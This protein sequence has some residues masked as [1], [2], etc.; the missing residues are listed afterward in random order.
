MEAVINLLKKSGVSIKVGQ[1]EIIITNN[2]KDRVPFKAVNVRTHEYPGFPT[3]LQ[4]P[5][6]VFLTQ[7]LGESSVFETIFEGRFKYAEDLIG[8]G[9]DIKI[10]NSREIVVKGPSVLKQLPEGEDLYA[11]DIRAGF[12]VVLAALVSKGTS[13]INNINLIDRGYQRLEE[14]LKLLGAD[15]RRV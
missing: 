7:A 2:S 6:A 5:M 12:A 9:A 11:H 3:D 15:V 10:L 4:A 1:E 14:R 8:M 13:K